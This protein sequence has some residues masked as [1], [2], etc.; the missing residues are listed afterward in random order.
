MVRCENDSA[1]ADDSLAGFGSAPKG[2]TSDSSTVR[3]VHGANEGTFPI[4]GHT[5]GAVALR[6][7][8]VFNIPPSAIGLV[9]G[10]RVS[11]SHVLA[12]GDNLEFL[13]PS[14]R[15]GGVHEYWSEDEVAQIF[16][17]KAVDEMRK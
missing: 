9:N 15:K 8:I 5:V 13:K 10:H 1:Q 11:S 4:A 14:G 12:E 2:E 3:V 17:A 16:G 6:L 7:R